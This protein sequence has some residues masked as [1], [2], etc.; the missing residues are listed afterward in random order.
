MGAVASWHDRSIGGMAMKKQ[1]ISSEI[2]AQA[3]ELAK[4][5]RSNQERKRKDR[6]DHTVSV[7]IN[8]DK[9][10]MVCGSAHEMVGMFTDLIKK[11]PEFLQV[12]NDAIR[13]YGYSNCWKL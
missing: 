7:I 11:R 2:N 8:E 13:K 6:I 1:I 12:L 5:V 3:L 4:A 9:A 10:L